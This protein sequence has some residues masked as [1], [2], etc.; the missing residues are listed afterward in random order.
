MPMYMQV[1]DVTYSAPLCGCDGLCMHLK[2]TAVVQLPIEWLQVAGG[3]HSGQGLSCHTHCSLCEVEGL[4]VCKLFNVVVVKKGEL[5]WDTIQ[6]ANL[7]EQV[8]R[9][10]ALYMAIY[11]NIC[12][13]IQICIVGI[14]AC[15]FRN[16]THA[17][18]THLH[19]WTALQVGL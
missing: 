10:Y 7:E 8:R 1:R 14:A 19:Y 3:P 18:S 17:H 13:T 2:V 16:S 6:Y 12:N 5:D 11:E 15:C 4:R 9:T